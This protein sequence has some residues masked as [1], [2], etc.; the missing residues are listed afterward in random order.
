MKTQREPKDGHQPT[1]LS[2]SCCPASSSPQAHK[3]GAT[4]ALLG[5]GGFA[6]AVFVIWRAA[7]WV[8]GPLDRAARR[9]SHPVQF[10]LADLLCLFILVDLP[11]GGIHCLVPNG[12]RTPDGVIAA[13]VV[14]TLVAALVWWTGVRTLSRAGIHGTWQRSFVLAVVIPAGYAGPFIIGCLPVFI[15]GL[16]LN[17]GNLPLV[18]KLTVVE[19][20]TGGVVYSLGRITRAMVASASRPVGESSST[21]DL[22]DK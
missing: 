1:A 17:D 9:R 7:V 6:L 10:S 19:I 12:D 14:V 21:G 2:A 18:M 5:L 4:L 15:I 8:L 13:D 20:T 16:W 11:M 22:P 3:E